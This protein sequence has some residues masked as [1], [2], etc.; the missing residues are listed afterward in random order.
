MFISSLS[1]IVLRQ[2]ISEYNGIESYQPVINGV[3]GNLVSIYSA[4]LSTEISRDSQSFG[5]WSDWAPN[6]YRCFP[7]DTFCG[8]KS[9][10]SNFKFQIFLIV[11]LF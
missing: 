8:R 1:G 7:R 11:A 2:A 9:R 10:Q 5:T 4:R 6:K 3:G